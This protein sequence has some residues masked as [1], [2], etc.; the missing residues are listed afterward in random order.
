MRHR[1]SPFFI[2]VACLLI[3]PVTADDSISDSAGPRQSPGWEVLE[4]SGEP[5]AR[6]EACFI[7]HDEKLYLIGG[8]RINPV[9]VFDPVTNSWTA[10]SAPPRELHHFQGVSIDGIIHLVGAMSGRWPRETP[11]ERVMT[12]D[13]ESDQFR[14]THPIP[15]GR[16]RGGAGAVAYQGKIYLVGGI[17]NGHMDGFQPWLDCYDPKTGAWKVLPD[18]PH[19]RD[20]FQATVIG[21]RMYVVAGRTT[22]Q[23]T[24]Q[25][26]NLTVAETD[27]FDF[28]TQ[29]W[30]AEGEFGDV[31]T[32]RAGNSTIAWDGNL[33]VGGGESGNQKRAHNEVESYDPATNQWVKLPP[34][35]QGR[36]GTGFG[37]VGDYLYTAS[38]SGNR[39]GRPELTTIERI[40]LSDLAPLPA[41]GS[42]EKTSN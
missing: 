34:L 26:F 31:P 23:K 4:V 19:S 11:L 5:T 21:D 17:T 42:I 9:D 40:K 29:Q 15:V 36:H 6:H 35:R 3:L 24:K 18:A 1:S 7:A 16:R 25:G 27:V 10:K 8:R 39:G 30:L 2:V 22:S 33:L 32:Q 12:Y 38:G 13:P 37:I 20:H 14:S 41:D 28:P